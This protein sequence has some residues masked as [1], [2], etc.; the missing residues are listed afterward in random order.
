M[1]MDTENPLTDSMEME[2]ERN[3]SMSLDDIEHS[4]LRESE[5]TW[6]ENWWK[7]VGTGNLTVKS[8]L[9]SR[10]RTFTRVTPLPKKPVDV[11]EVD[12]FQFIQDE[13]S[14]T[15]YYDVILNGPQGL[16]LNLSVSMTGK[17]VVQ[18]LT[19]LTGGLPSPAMTAGT[20]KKNDV[21]IGINGSD[22]ERMDLA[23]VTSMM[24]LV[25][26]TGKVSLHQVL[27]IALIFSI[28]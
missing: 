7:S 4:W 16:G 22:L 9:A 26:K 15:D 25:E 19:R 18:G 17:V 5:A 2:N 21:L 10:K 13:Q 27:F 11:G 23:E 20:I 12:L 28:A 14:A 6:L 1:R 8:R 24:K 3:L